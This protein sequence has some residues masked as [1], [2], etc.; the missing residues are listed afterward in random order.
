MMSDKIT[1][2][3]SDGYHTFNE[4]YHHRAVLF[5][6]LQKAYPELSWKSTLHSDGTMFDDFFITGIK[7]P[8]G[9]YSY[10]FDISE[11]EIF[12]CK[13]LDRAPEWDGHMPKDVD[14]LL[15]LKPTTKTKTWGDVQVEYFHRVE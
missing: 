1:G 11:W 15:S 14:R 10:H 5:A 12:Q 4:L 13:E 3:T 7:T 8:E 2:E 9:Y 6:A